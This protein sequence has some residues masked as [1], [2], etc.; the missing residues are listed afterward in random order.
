ME[1]S[2][3]HVPRIDDLRA[4]IANAV[5]GPLEREDEESIARLYAQPA[6]DPGLVAWDSPVAR[7]HADLPAML[8]GGFAALLLQTL[9]PGAMAGVADHSNYRGDPYGRL[10]RT[11]RFIA[12]TTYGNRHEA[13]RATARV[14]AIHARVRGVRPDGVP[15]VADDPELLCWVHTTEAWSFLRAATV[16][17]PAPLSPAERDRYFADA[18]VVAEQLGATTVPRTSAQA[19]A[20]LSSL[21]PG[22]CYGAQAREAVRFLLEGEREGRGE[23]AGV[24]FLFQLAITLLP[25]WA[26]RL[27]ELPAIDSLR[28]RAL[29]AAARGL[30]PA[31]RWA[32]GPHPLA[33]AQQLRQRVPPPETTL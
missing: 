20:Y 13:L 14:R 2:L 23:E 9:H 17:G 6:G 30:F 22:L 12:V 26:A 11:A 27:L 10:R 33:A 8:C 32:L 16:F 3:T 1:L 28:R 25:V 18:A 24:R 15:Y 7:V 21:R 31:V 5:R 4:F 19:E 29:Y